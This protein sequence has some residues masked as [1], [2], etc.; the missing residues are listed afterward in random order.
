[1]LSPAN[2][3]EPEPLPTDTAATTEPLDKSLE[4]LQREREEIIKVPLKV[5]RP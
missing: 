1:M 5:E 3:T 4:R 2:F